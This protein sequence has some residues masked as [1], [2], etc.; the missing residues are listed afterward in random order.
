M[1]KNK[2]AFIFG[3]LILILTTLA[4]NLSFKNGNLTTTITI[5]KEQLMTIINGAQTVAGAVADE[6]LMAEVDDIQFIE[7]DKVKLIGSFQAPNATKTE[8]EVE[9]VFSVENEKPKVEIT[10]VNIPGLDLAS[11]AIKNLNEK[12]SEVLN[13]QINLTKETAVIKAIYVKDDALKIDIEVP[14]KK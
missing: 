11:D 1:K 10:W 14:I 12:L 2:K 6:A 13:D 3:V 8:G 4:C 5:K 9:M 7:P